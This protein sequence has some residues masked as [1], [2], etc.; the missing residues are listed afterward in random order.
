M[1]ATELIAPIKGRRKF[2]RPKLPFEKKKEVLSVMIP[3]EL[4]TDLYTLS[5]RCDKSISQ[6]TREALSLIVHVYDKEKI[7]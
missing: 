5:V 7:A 6:L 1:E 3:N 2:G 4:R